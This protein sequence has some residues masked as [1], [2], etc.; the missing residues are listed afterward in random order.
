MVPIALIVGLGNVGAEY[1]AT[2]HNAGFW[3][4]NNLAKQTNAT[5]RQETKF[6]GEVARLEKS[7]WKGWLLKPTTFMNRSGQSVIALANFY[8]ISPEQILVVHDE[9]DLPVGTARLKQGGGHGGH[10]GLKDIIA[11]LGA[12]FY[13]LRIGI[14]HPGNRAEVVNYVLHAPSR[15]EQISIDTSIDAALKIL[16]FLFKDEMAKAMQVLHS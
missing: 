3:F 11:N 10:N 9:L 14:G 4:V 15:D 2:R 13:R 16:P 7:D 12:N 1:E 5:F 8:K 6:H